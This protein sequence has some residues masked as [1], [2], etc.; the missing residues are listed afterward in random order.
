MDK[1]AF[2]V[3]SRGTTAETAERVIA[4][5]RDQLGRLL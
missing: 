5:M 1:A 3:L 4:N 2:E